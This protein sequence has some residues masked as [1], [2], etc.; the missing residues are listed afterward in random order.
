M[1]AFTDAMAR[2]FPVDPGEI[3][4]AI[5]VLRDIR[6]GNARILTRREAACILNALVRY[7]ASVQTAGATV[8]E[9]RDAG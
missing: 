9:A 3:R 2:M 7:E 1:S 6:T 4:Q 5:D 8:D